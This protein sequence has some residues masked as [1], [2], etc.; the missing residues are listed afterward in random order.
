M[1]IYILWNCSYKKIMTCVMNSWHKIM[2]SCAD[3]SLHEGYM[4]KNFSFNE[5]S[6]SQYEKVAVKIPQAIEFHKLS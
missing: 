6:I 3:N 5:I 1:I 2:N 4:I